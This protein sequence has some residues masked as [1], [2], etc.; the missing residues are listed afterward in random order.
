MKNG[1]SFQAESQSRP[2]QSPIKK[3]GRPDPDSTCNQRE[4]PLLF[5]FD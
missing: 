1:V 3:Y 5:P 4:Q 2:D